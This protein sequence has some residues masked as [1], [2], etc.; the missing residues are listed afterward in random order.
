VRD[1]EFVHRPRT[2]GAMTTAAGF[3]WAALIGALLGALLTGAL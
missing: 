3:L 2:V 1:Q